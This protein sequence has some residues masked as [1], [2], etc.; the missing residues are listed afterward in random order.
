MRKN[1]ATLITGI[2][3]VLLV[4]CGKAKP[5]LVLSKAATSP[6]G[7]ARVSLFEQTGLI[8]RNFEVR[9]ESSQIEARTIFSSPDEGKPIG[10]ERFIWSSD[11]RMVILVG[12][13]FLVAPRFENGRGEVLYFAYDVQAGR[14]WCNS[15]QTAGVGTFSPTDLLGMATWNP[16][17]S[18]VQFI[19]NR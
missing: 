3:I 14:S 8:D 5:K 12:K 15:S 19:Q 1:A 6:D 17:D 10:D 18:I 7:N 2:A 13:H 11:S 4:G 16:E 9:I